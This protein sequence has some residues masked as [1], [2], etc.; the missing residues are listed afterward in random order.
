MNT[1]SE[2]MK[3]LAIRIAMLC[4]AVGIATAAFAVPPNEVVRVQTTQIL[5]GACCFPW[6]ETVTVKEPSAP[7]PLVVTWSTDYVTSGNNVFFRVGVSVN[8]HPCIATGVIG[9]F[10]ST[11]GTFTSLTFQWNILPSDGLI[12][13]NNNITLCGGASAGTI[14][15]GSNTL[16]VRV[17]K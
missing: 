16:A 12:K 3:R 13:G 9:G 7:V 6:G 14:A 4:L 15:L 10:A 8:G 2:T 11:D 1:G 17:S 5:T